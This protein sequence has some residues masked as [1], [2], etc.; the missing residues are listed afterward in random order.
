MSTRVIRVTGKGQIKTHPDMTR[1]TI[2]LQGV[3]P[4]YDATL[5]ASADDTESLKSI[6]EK[7]GFKRTDLKPRGRFLW[8]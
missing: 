1:I 3:M 8:F 2:S 4:E 5:E 6:M 7:M